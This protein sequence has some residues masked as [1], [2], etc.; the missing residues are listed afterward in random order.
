MASARSPEGFHLTDALESMR[1]LFIA[2]GG[3]AQAA[4]F[5]IKIEHFEEFKRRFGLCA[6][7]ASAQTKQSASAN[8]P[9]IID[10]VL[11]PRAISIEFI[12]EIESFGPYGIG[13]GKP[14]FLVSFERVPNM[15]FLGT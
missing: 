10:T 11:D 9:I 7:T 14:R 8:K 1:E 12:E 2:F 13:F 3:H 5:S 4:G 15:D 6:E